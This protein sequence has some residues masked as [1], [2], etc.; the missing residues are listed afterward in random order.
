MWLSALLSACWNLT[1]A[2]QMHYCML[3]TIAPTS[4]DRP[5]QV[6]RPV[7]SLIDSLS[8]LSTNHSTYSSLRQTTDLGECL[9]TIRSTRKEGKFT[10]PL[11]AN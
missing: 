7:Y 9:D 5:S 4:P 10:T 1:S 11:A 6:D 2:E 8:G 3:G